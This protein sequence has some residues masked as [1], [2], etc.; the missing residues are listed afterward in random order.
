[1]ILKHDLASN[2]G[3]Q[4]ELGVGQGQA[5]AERAAS[6]IEHTVDHGDCCGVGPSDRRLGP[7]LR[8]AADVNFVIEGDRQEHFDAKLIDL[9]ECQ[10]R[11]L[12][13]AIL[14][15]IEEPLDDNAVDLAA[16]G[17]LIDDF[18]GVL[19]FE[20]RNFDGEF[21]FL[22][23]LLGNMDLRFGLLQRC[24]RADRF[25]LQG[26]DAC[27][28]EPQKLQAGFGGLHWRFVGGAGLR[29]CKR[30]RLDPILQHAE[31]LALVDYVASIDVEAR[32][33]A[34]DGTCDFDHLLGLDD[35]FVF[36]F[37]R[38]GPRRLLC[39]CR[40]GCE[41]QRDR[42]DEPPHRLS[43]RFSADRRHWVRPNVSKL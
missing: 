36:G 42:R 38:T 9:C 33:D 1:M 30:R 43:P 6:G 7:D 16:Q 19:D 20:A 35:A 31:D 22:E 12:L 28:L 26:L 18:L 17:P 14:A 41:H 29:K 2:S 32:Y 13:I 5:H 34:D 37:L 25:F 8:P 15:G 27:V 24:K 21:C 10:D 4:Q 23:L 3:R 11:G 40:R 39:P